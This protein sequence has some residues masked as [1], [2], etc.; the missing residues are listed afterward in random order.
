[1]NNHIILE[2][3]WKI[4]EIARN[5]LKGYWKPM[6]VATLIFYLL[7]NGVGQVLS[8]VFSY[9]TS[10]VYVSFGLPNDS[11]INYPSVNYGGSIYDFLVGGAFTLGFTMLLLTF[12]RTKRVDYSLNF[13]GFSFF[14]KAFLLQLLIGIKVFLWTLLFIVPGIVAGYRYSQAFYILADNPDYSVT[15][16]VEESKRL[17][18]GN[19][20]RLF[21]LELTFIGWALLA[22]IPTGL[23]IALF[24]DS[25]FF[26]VIASLI[27]ALPAIFVYEYVYVSKAAFYELLTERLVV[28][29]P[30][31]PTDNTVETTYTVYE[32]A[33]GQ[34][35]ETPEEPTE[36]TE[37]AEPTEPADKNE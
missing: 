31:A 26:A 35:Q 3:A 19:K 33:P 12:F 22:S 16:C 30:S 29:F 24:P 21:Y 10:E 9:D 27:A 1:M 37:T 36:P 18:M 5:A 32:Q 28:V 8:Y 2:P 14:V 15:Q 25:G 17:M 6:F 13:E 7:T 4:R 34:P 20:G 11:Y 23:I